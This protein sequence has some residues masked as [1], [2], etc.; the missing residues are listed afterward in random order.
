M[1]GFSGLPDEALQLLCAVELSVF[2]RFV[3]GMEV[4]VR[5]HDGCCGYYRASAGFWSIQEKLLRQLNHVCKR[6][7]HYY[8]FNL[9]LKR[10]YHV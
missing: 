3:Q 5:P 8:H 7:K 10:D 2:Y 9:S 1:S 4:G 6:S